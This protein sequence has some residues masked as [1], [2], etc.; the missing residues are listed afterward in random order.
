MLFHQSGSL[1]GWGGEMGSRDG[2]KRDLTEHVRGDCV[3][4]GRL[5]VATATPP[6]LNLHVLALCKH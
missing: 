6:S 5:L 2:I 1:R 3:E 4:G